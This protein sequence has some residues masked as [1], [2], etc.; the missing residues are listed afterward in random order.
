MPAGGGSKTNVVPNKMYFGGVLRARNHGDP[1]GDGSRYPIHEIAHGL[2]RTIP[3]G[4]TLRFYS[5]YL[6]L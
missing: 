4:L 3:S 1:T 5:D 6:G 2:R